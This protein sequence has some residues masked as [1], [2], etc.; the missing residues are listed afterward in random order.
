MRIL[1]EEELK[2]LHELQHSK[3]TEQ[4]IE[5]KKK[6][7]IGSKTFLYPIRLLQA[8]GTFLSI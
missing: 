4:Q 7:L 1:S 8:Q 6:R 2:I 5:E 3:L